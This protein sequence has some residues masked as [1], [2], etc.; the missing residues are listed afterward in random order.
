M[1]SVT[2]WR[3]DA[4]RIHMTTSDRDQTDDIEPVEFASDFCLEL[5]VSFTP[6]QLTAIS[7]LARERE[8]GPSEAAQALVEQALAARDVKQ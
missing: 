7:Q 5:S 3:A 6:E 8:I 1:L 2:E 4:T